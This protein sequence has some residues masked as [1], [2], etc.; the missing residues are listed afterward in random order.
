MTASP[1]QHPEELEAE[2]RRHELAKHGAYDKRTEH[3]TAEGYGLFIN[4]LIR[5]DSPYLLQHAHNPVNWFPWGDE[6]FAC[7]RE[8][9]KP[10][11]LSIGYATCHWCHVMEVESFDNPAV[12]AVLNEHFISVKMDREQY[13]DIDEIYMT[14]V[15]LMTGHG[16]WPMSNLLL[17]SGEP[18]FGATYF[19]AA[20]FIA[21]LEQVVVAWRDKREELETSARQMQAGIEKILG[22]RKAVAELDANL[23]QNSLQALLQREDRERGGLAGEPKFPQE[24][25]LLLLLDAAARGAEEHALG[26][27]DR[28]LEGMGRGGIY[29]QIG[30]GFARYSVDEDWLVPHFEKML[31]NQSQ[32]GL[33]L[34][35]AFELT[36]KPFFL[37]LLTQTL[38]YVLR[39]MQR[40]E[41]GFYSATDADS[42]GEEGVFFTWSLAELKE[43]LNADEFAL[44]NK[45]YE[46]TVL[47]NFE[48]ANILKL[49]RALEVSAR[50]SDDPN[51][52][53]TLDAV[54]DK[55]YHLRETRIHPLRDD[56][57]IVAWS[58]AMATTLARAGHRLQSEHWSEAAAR[59]AKVICEE[60]I[61]SAG[62]LSRIALAGTVSIKG[63]LE[64]YAALAECLIT[65]FDLGQ[66]DQALLTAQRVVDTMIAEFWDE[67]ADGFFLSPAEQVG[68]QLTR[69]KSA[70]DGATLSPVG[71]ALRCLWL[72]EQRQAL[73]TKGGDHDYGGLFR[74]GLVAVSGQ[75]NEHPLSHPS[76]LRLE[77]QSRDLSCRPV[78]YVDGGLAVCRVEKIEDKGENRSLELSVSAAKGWHVELGFG[79]G[80]GVEGE[81]R[82]QSLELEEGSAW[83]ILSQTAFEADDETLPRR[84]II[85]VEAQASPA[86]KSSLDQ[87]LRLRLGVR[88]CNEREC[89]LPRTIVVYA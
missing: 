42:E 17:P 29:D 71:T 59:T 76:L 49:S 58:A 43:V 39:D 30:G 28:A 88:L 44:V 7:A 74:R 38:D 52:Y 18:F 47:G 85:K 20:Q 14:G 63:Q 56:K 24:P 2:L 70:S 67:T 13:P 16:G 34:L 69:S 22:D 8:Q 72:L 77:E 31:Y 86:M 27:V 3:L 40:P 80:A 79:A 6:A 61:D 83:R 5:E 53:H 26:F 1:Q 21:I 19:P 68:P 36:R 87:A 57:L 62:K 89:L 35:E 33:V 84:T 66:D 78:A 45:L 32:L 75:L 82:P 81:L 64:D 37:R 65:L 23:L 51:F 12:A 9:N 4:R 73:L 11:F 48:G 10:V 25:L 54:L 55:L 50:E 15:Q 60:N 41:G 46:P